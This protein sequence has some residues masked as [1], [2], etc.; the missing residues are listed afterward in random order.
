MGPGRQMEVGIGKKTG[1]VSLLSRSIGTIRMEAV[2]SPCETLWQCT[3]ATGSIFW[4]W[5][6]CYRWP[7]DVPTVRRASSRR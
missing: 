3:A 6:R 5:G 7:G 2:V 4:G 1:R